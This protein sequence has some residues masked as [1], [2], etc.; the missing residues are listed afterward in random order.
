MRSFVCVF[1]I[2]RSF[3]F[4]H[5]CIE[6]SFHVSCIF[7]IVR[8]KHSFV[9]FAFFVHLHLVRIVNL[10][11]PGSVPTLCEK[12]HQYFSQNVDCI[13]HK[14]CMNK[15]VSSTSS[16]SKNQCFGLNVNHLKV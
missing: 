8:V 1:R 16:G 10:Y 4:V 9:S 13:E 11:D 2:V 14:F 12:E 3:H 6:C 5:S 15:Q 7:R